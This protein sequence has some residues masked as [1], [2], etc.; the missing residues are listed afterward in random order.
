MDRRCNSQGVGLTK[1][2]LSWLSRSRLRPKVEAL[3]NPILPSVLVMLVLLWHFAPTP[4]I[5]ILR[6]LIRSDW[7][8]SNQCIYELLRSGHNN[9]GTFRLGKM[10]QIA[11]DQKL[12][13]AG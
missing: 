11:S 4:G 13:V 1:E 5:R 9:T 6:R 8:P 12:S 7:S 3:D 2:I 10:L